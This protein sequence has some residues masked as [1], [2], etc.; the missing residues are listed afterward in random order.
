[1]CGIW[2]CV[3][4]DSDVLSLHEIFKANQK[5]GPDDFQIMK[6]A[7]DT[8]TMVFYRLAIRDVRSEGMQPFL[9]QCSL[10]GDQYV[11]VCNGEIY[12]YDQLLE[13]FPMVQSRLASKSDCEIILE[14]YLHLGNN[15]GAVLEYIRG[16]FAFVLVEIDGKTSTVRQ[17]YAARDPYGVRPLFIGSSTTTTTSRIVFSSLLQGLSGGSIVDPSTARQL[18]P[19]HLLAFGAGGTV[20]W[21]KPYYAPRV[22]FLSSCSSALTVE[23]GE[24]ACYREVCD[25]LIEAVRQRMISDRPIG[26]LLSGGLDSSLVVAIAHKI[27]GVPVQTFTIGLDGCES[28]D[29]RYAQEVIDHLKLGDQATIV[30]L[31]VQEALGS[32]EEVIRECETYDIT[33]I[34]ASIMQYAMARHIRDHTPIRVIL[35]GDG[36]DEVQMGYLYFRMAPHAMA[37]R[38]ENLKLLREIHFFDGLRVDRCLGA[39]GLEARLPFLDID[40]VDYFL[41]LPTEWTAPLNGR[42]EKSLIRK[43][44][45]FCYPDLL[46]ESVLFR[47]KEAFS[48]GVSSSTDSWHQRLKNH[49]EQLASVNPLS[50]DTGVNPPISTESLYYRTIFTKHFPGMDRII[51]HFWQP[52]F[53]TTSDPSARELAIYTESS[54]S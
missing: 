14:L 51:P 16:E 54:S 2:V 3:G 30:R 39:M 29:I 33:T 44:F 34:R 53:T 43:A 12:N 19:G 18:H 7:N 37:A 24:I 6:L 40:F 9:R 41:S 49:V 23:E 26:A 15:M 31:S 52:A 46:P 11:L 38:H 25:R 27:I 8:V 20:H 45:H 1:M 13:D 4:E 32:I 48:D 22:F 21:Q 10:T 42:P 35:N 50:F 17:G 47:Q 28:T 5:R 36:A